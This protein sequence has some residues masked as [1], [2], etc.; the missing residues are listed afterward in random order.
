MAYRRK[1]YCNDLPSAQ[2]LKEWRREEALKRI[3]RDLEEIDSLDDQECEEFDRL[4]A[5]SKK[6]NIFG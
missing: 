1:F 6:R 3:V 2:E 4:Y 5:D